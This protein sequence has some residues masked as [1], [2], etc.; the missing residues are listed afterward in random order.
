MAKK[1]SSKI[2]KT[3]YIVSGFPRSG[4]SLMMRMLEAGGMEVL[5]TPEWRKSTVTDTYGPFEFQDWNKEILKHPK[6][7]TGDKVFKVVAP[8]MQAL[9]VDRNWKCIFMIRDINKIITSLLA[10][11]T[12]WEFE[13]GETIRDALEYLEHHKIPT[14]RVDL[15]ELVKY[16][17]TTC[18]EI[19]KFCDKDLDIEKMVATTHK[20]GRKKDSLSGNLLEFSG[21]V[22]KVE[23]TQMEKEIHIRKWGK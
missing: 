13:P 12:I 6:S 11:Q 21:Q 22:E 14:L 4:T 19:A 16:P 8:Y 20:K 1:T 10:M 18:V 5:V 7:W 9:S 3:S 17:K 2:L 15:E 23:Y